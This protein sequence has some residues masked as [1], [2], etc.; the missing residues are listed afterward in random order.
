MCPLHTWCVG[1][2]RYDTIYLRLRAKR[3]DPLDLLLERNEALVKTGS[4]A[5]RRAW[6]VYTISGE[7]DWVV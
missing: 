4:E 5:K 1:G 2:E 6:T 3:F 7:R